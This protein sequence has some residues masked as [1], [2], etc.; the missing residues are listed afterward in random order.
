[1]K[2]KLFKS[3]LLSTSL[4]LFSACS[5]KEV[6]EPIKLDADWKAYETS[7]EAIIDTSSNVALLEDRTVL[8]EDGS[9]VDITVAP[10][11][12]LI[13]QSDEWI[14]SASVDGNVTLVFKNDI[15]VF[16]HLAL[17]KS[18]AGASVSGNELAVLFADNEMAIYDIDTQATLFKEQGGKY[19][20]VDSRVVNPIFMR[21][22]VLFGTLDGKVVFVNQ[23]KR[24]RLRTVIVSSEDNFNNVIAFNVVENKII[25]AT[26]Y[27][28]LSMAKKEIRVKY[29]LRS[30]VYDTNRV[31]IATKQG[32]II[33][34]TSNLQ[35]ESKVKFPFA[36]FYAM[37]VVGEKLYVLE[38]E[39]YLIV[40]DK[41]SFEYTVH[42]VDFDDG[43]V[44]TTK[45]TFFVDDK[46]ILTE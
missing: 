27:K 35:V 24:K 36:H 17:K 37:V 31:Y 4:L 23:A 46:K 15:T 41:N 22:L 7:K 8:T 29:E 42:E 6:Y 9:I 44:F 12:R 20:A 32:E 28:I 40:L 1:L 34:L 18:V 5:S 39:G 10:S 11:F 38:K 21:G 2:T 3:A 13:S 25:A 33:S 14:V 19:T 16:K 30:I 43:F 45:D 26:S